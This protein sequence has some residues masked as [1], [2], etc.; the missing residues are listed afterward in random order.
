[1]AVESGV[2]E[3][4]RAATERVRALASLADDELRHPVGEHW[5]VSIALAHLAFWDR[6]VLDV[7][8]RAVL[9]GAIEAPAVDMAVNDIALPGWAAIPPRDAVRLAMEAAQALD[10]RLAGL[11]PELLDAV[12]ARS[13]RWVRRSLHRNEHLD[14]V[15]AALRR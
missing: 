5:T 3:A 6:R 2:H 1:M 9:A 12:D 11:P 10:A 7:I 14:E 13:P 4:N 8:E 15:E